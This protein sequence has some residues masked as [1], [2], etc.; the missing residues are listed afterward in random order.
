MGEGQMGG[1]LHDRPAMSAKLHALFRGAVVHRELGYK[2]G[3][4]V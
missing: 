1:R 2:A 4:I 3:S